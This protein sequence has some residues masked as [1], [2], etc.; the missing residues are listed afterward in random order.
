MRGFQVTDQKAV[1]HSTM[2]VVPAGKIW[3]E[4]PFGGAVKDGFVWG[5]GA[6]DMKG[7][8]IIELAMLSNAKDY[9]ERRSYFWH[10]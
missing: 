5:R 8:A 3:K 6:L 9:V 4:P 7:P 10:R 1:V 2:D